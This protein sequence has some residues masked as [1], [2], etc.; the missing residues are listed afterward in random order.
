MQQIIQ[1]RH[2]NWPLMYS[3][4]TYKAFKVVTT[5][6]SIAC[7]YIYKKLLPL[8]YRQCRRYK[9]K[10][11]TSDQNKEGNFFDSLSPFKFTPTSH[12]IANGC[13]MLLT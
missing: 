5:L 1:V 2:A 9:V 4:S 13:D 3:P 6:S 12:V 10:S 11:I 8:H 7:S